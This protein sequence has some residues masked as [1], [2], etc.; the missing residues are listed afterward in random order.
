LCACMCVVKYKHVGVCVHAFVA[1]VCS[2]KVAVLLQVCVV[3]IVSACVV[4]R[5]VAVSWS[6]GAAFRYRVEGNIPW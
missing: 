6:W 4:L 1:W 3:T 2:S 5:V